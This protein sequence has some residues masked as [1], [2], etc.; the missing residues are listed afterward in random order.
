MAA[1]NKMAAMNKM[2]ANGQAELSSKGQS[3]QNQQ[4]WG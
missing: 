1:L 4:N 3:T 2:V